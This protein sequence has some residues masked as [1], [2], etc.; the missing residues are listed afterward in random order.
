MMELK[1]QCQGHPVRILYAFDPRRIAIL[2]C[3]GDKKGD[4]RW[5]KKNV[6]IA[7][8]LYRQHLLLLKEEGRE[9][10]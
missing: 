9:E 7:D 8:E 6:P 3:G 2:L 10:K 4:D 1:V 5:Y